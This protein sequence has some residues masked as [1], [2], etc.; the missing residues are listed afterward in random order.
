MRV[1][2]LAWTTEALAV[3]RSRTWNDARVVA[4]GERGWGRGRLGE[5]AAPW[6]GQERGP[7]AQQR[8]SCAV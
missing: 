3:E 8:P 4:H 2:W 6:P 7:Q 1:W 5:N